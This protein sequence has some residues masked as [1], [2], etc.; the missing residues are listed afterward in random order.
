MPSQNTSGK[1]TPQ[2]AQQIEDAITLASAAIGVTA[3]LAGIPG[4]GA[5]AGAAGKFLF[6]YFAPGD[7]PAAI[8]YKALAE[9]IA[10]VEKAMLEEF[11]VLQS[12]LQALQVDILELQNEITALGVEIDLQ[13]YDSARSIINQYYSDFSDYTTALTRPGQTKT[14]VDQASKDLFELL[15]QSSGAAN[16]VSVA[17]KNLRNAVTN[18]DGI[19]GLISRQRELVSLVVQNWIEDRGNYSAG[20]ISTPRVPAFQAYNNADIFTKAYGTAGPKAIDQYVAPLLSDIMIMQYRGLTFLANAIGGTPL[21]PQLAGHIEDARLIFAS[22]ASLSTELTSET[23]VNHAVSRGIEIAPLKGGPGIEAL[24]PSGAEGDAAYFK[25]YVIWRASSSS[26]H[27]IESRS[28]SFGQ[29]YASAQLTYSPKEGPQLYQLFAYTRDR[30][31]VPEPVQSLPSP[32]SAKLNEIEIRLSKAGAEEGSPQIDV[33]QIPSVAKPEIA[34][35]VKNVEHPEADN[36]AVFQV[37]SDRTARTGTRWTLAQT[38]VAIAPDGTF[39]AQVVVQ[40]PVYWVVFVVKSGWHWADQH[41]GEAP[42]I[43]SDVVAYN[44]LVAA[45]QG[46]LSAE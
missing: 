40:E 2:E 7:T 38:G 13:T 22:V 37:I 24:P 36:V 31:T 20:T 30:T 33:S 17:M 19:E 23:T 11:H 21:Q 10:Q 5:L 34:G 44:A 12:E 16:A 39:K 26:I 4:V 15:S 28:L 35:T 32:F 27:L 9:E 6:D 3:S 43:T 25:D 29:T 46:K 8:Y 1:L 45:R 42:D 18:T 41:K 14:G